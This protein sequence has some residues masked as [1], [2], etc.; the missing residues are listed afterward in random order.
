[1]KQLAYYI[2]SL[3][4][5]QSACNDVQRTM[6]EMTVSSLA[7]SIFCT[8]DQQEFSRSLARKLSEDFPTAEIVGS[9]ASKLILNGE[10]YAQGV[11]MTFSLFE[12]ARLIP[13]AY[14]FNE[15]GPEEIGSEILRLIAETENPK[16]VGINV[17][18]SGNID[19]RPLWAVLSHADSEIKFFGGL[20]DEG[21][22]GEIGLLFNDSAMLR[23][24]IGGSIFCGEDLRVKVESDFGWK[25]L[26]KK[27]TI[28]KLETPYIIKELDFEPPIRAYERYLGIKND[29]NFLIDTLTFP[30]YLERYGTVIARHP[31]MARDDDGALLFNADF[32]EGEK[33]RIAYGD[34]IGIIEGA[35]GIRRRLAEFRPQGI[36]SISCIARWLLLGSDISHES[37]DFHNMAPMNG[38]YAFGELIRNKGQVILSNMTMSVIGIREG[39]PAEGEIVPE[40]DTGGLHLNAQTNIMKHM[41]H[42][43]SV[44]SKELE[45]DNV[46]LKKMAE[47]D[48]LTDLYNR[49]ELEHVLAKKLKDKR[50]AQKNFSVLM[51]DIDDFKD[52]NDSFGHD[53]GDRAIKLA[54][55]VIREH[56]RDT[57][58]PGRWG[59]DEFFVILSGATIEEAAMLGERIRKAMCEARILPDDYQIT[60]SIGVT[61]S[62]PGDTVATLY[63]RADKALYQAKQDHGKNNVCMVKG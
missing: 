33:V 35:K 24:G 11:T 39:E 26:G 18:G 1:M 21:D 23:S 7:A 14:D 43:I 9:V 20:S 3:S 63:K 36:Y 10:F 15:M 2:K 45:K 42:F 49:G 61:E 46:D 52:I 58:Y 25:P 50:R 27:M 59:G 31:L 28:T 8:S 47:T 12:R 34:P 32:Q 44:S 16:A 22:M 41:V 38:Y 30:L 60:T 62:V 56:T 57:D 53:S 48:R 40:P 29:Y 51:M 37:E 54:A 19:L 13:F 5:Y 17:A 6:K 55:D 4:D